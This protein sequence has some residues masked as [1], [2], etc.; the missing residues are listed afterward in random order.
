MATEKN[1]IPKLDPELNMEVTDKLLRDKPHIGESS[2]G[3]YYLYNVEK[4]GFEKSF[5]APIEIHEVLQ[6]NKLKAGSEF[7]L[8]KIMDQSKPKLELALVAASSTGN[9]NHT[10]NQDNLKEIMLQCVRD[11][12]DIV[13]A[14]KEVPF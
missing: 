14:V 4:G 1:N 2:F 13:N 5:F 3:K 11:S 12:A 6:A 8:K 10:P 9:G 7:K